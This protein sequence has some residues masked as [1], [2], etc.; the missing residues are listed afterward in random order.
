VRRDQG[1]RDPAYGDPDGDPLGDS[2]E[3]QAGD[4]YLALMHRALHE[5]YR[6]PPT[7]SDRD[8]LHLRATVVLFIEPDGKLSR[9]TFREKS[10]NGAFDEALARAVQQARFPPPPAELRQE[11]RAVGLLVNFGM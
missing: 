7:I 5:T 3:G 10:G 4:R 1:R 11:V 8:R 2:S 9:W 6:L